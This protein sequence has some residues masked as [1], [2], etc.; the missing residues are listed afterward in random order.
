MVLLEEE[1][2][3]TNDSTCLKIS[4]PERRF[5]QSD[6]SDSE[7]NFKLQSAI[8]V[9]NGI[10]VRESSRIPASSLWFVPLHVNNAN[11]KDKSEGVTWRL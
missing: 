2:C 1:E 8:A 3:V 4:Q 10:A 5:L 6:I 9:G 7:R 11:V